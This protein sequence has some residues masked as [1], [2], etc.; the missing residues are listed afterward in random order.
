M[1]T[2][3]FLQRVTQRMQVQPAIELQREGQVK[4]GCGRI[5]LEQL[6]ESFL[7]ESERKF[8]LRS[9]GIAD[10]RLCGA[11]WDLARAELLLLRCSKGAGQVPGQGLDVGL[12][13]NL[14]V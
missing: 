14:F 8:G 1:S 3:D 2:H 5:A 11:A 10:A 12:L 7:G 6:P 13:Q 4:A 9:G